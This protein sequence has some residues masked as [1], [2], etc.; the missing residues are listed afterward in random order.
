M[1]ARECLEDQ[2][3]AD[4]WDVSV[5]AREKIL[6]ASTFL[7]L[8]PDFRDFLVMPYYSIEKIMIIPKMMMMKFYAFARPD[9]PQLGYIADMR[10]MKLFFQPRIV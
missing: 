7:K 1:F 6:S 2:M 4:F 3:P 8:I 5:Q 10:I 9:S